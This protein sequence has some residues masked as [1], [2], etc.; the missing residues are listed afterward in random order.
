ML[1]VFSLLTLEKFRA[2]QR[3]SLQ[4]NQDVAE[5]LGF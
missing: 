4:V 1:R 2:T 5:S 3:Y